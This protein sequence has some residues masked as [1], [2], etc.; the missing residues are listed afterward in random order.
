MVKKKFNI[1]YH[2]RVRGTG[3]EGVHIAGIVNGFRVLGH[4]VRLLSPTNTDPTV[5]KKSIS[6]SQEKTSFPAFILHKLADLLPQPFFELMEMAYNLVAIPR[7]WRTVSREHTDLIYERYAFFNIA[8]AFISKIKGLPLVLEV[9]ELSGDKRVRKQSFVSLCSI[10]EL[11]VFRQAALV[12]TVSNYLSDEV[13][14]RLDDSGQLV[15]TMPNGVPEAWLR[16]NIPSELSLEL[17]NRYCLAGKRVICFMGGLVYWHNF[18]LLLE[19][20]KRV[21][22][23]IDNVVLLIIGDGPLRSYIHEAAVKFALEPNSIIFAG[24][25]PHARIPVYLSLA[26]VAVIPETNDFRSPIKLFEYMAM[27][28]PVVAPKKPAIE[29]AITHN[30]SGLL[31][32]PGNAGSLANM[33]EECFINPKMIKSL[34]YN[35]HK[36]IAEKFTWEK[37]SERILQAFQRYL[38]ET[39]GDGLVKNFLD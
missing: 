12:I 1:L 3:A 2:F 15:I 28:L 7:L 30:R 39:K 34:G 22:S 11:F 6:T 14:R 23:R 13:H 32:E 17:Q 19:A 5:P 10:F 9:N 38:L 31:F 33:L 24:N 25:I 21:Q 20:V 35:A 29:I 4:T 8:G 37:N 18:D 36:E 16:H 27:E 26:D